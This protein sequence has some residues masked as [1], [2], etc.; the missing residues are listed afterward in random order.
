ME[1]YRMKSWHVAEYR[2]KKNCHPRCQLK[3]GC[4]LYSSSGR[5]LWLIS[6]AGQHA[7][8]CVSTVGFAMQHHVGLSASRHLS[9]CTIAICLQHRHGMHAACKAVLPLRIQA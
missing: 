6:L 2:L 1:E 5:L 4:L 9:V 3:A 7:W 8:S